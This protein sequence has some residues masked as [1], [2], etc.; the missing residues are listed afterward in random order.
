HEPRGRDHGPRG[1]VHEPRGCNHEPR[2]RDHEPRGRVPEPPSWHASCPRTGRAWGEDTQWRVSGPPSRRG[3]NA[4]RKD[5]LPPAHGGGGG[6]GGDTRGR[7]GGPPPRRGTNAPRK[8]PLPPAGG[9]PRRALATPPP[10]RPARQTHGWSRS[11]GERSRSPS[12]LI[13]KSHP[14]VA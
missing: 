3:T 7:V 9:A 1:S 6:G 12:S 4:P 5:P 2:G 10:G 8:D 11:Q 13:D 14:P